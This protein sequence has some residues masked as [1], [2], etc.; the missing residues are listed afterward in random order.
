LG[1]YYF[2]T[3]VLLELL[4]YICKIF[5]AE[6]KVKGKWDIYNKFAI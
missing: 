2:T 3:F 1:F 6:E 5:F 4:F